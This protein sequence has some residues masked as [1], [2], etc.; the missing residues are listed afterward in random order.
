M[1]KRIVSAFFATLILVAVAFAVP[2]HDNQAAAV[3]GDSIV[4]GAGAGVFP[5]GASFNSIEL[6]GGTFGLGAQIS[7]TGSANGTLEVQ[8]TGTSLIGLSQWITINGWITSATSNPDGSVTLNGTG[9]L[10][11]GDGTPPTGGLALVANAGPGGLTVTIG[12]TTLPTLPK[13]D[14][15]VINE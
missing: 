13:S 8:F 4:T 12:G 10:D 9:T 14:G 1:T 11:L 3:V 2:R 6:A 15:W 5:A 7:T